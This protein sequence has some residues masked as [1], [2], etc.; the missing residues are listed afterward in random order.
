MQDPPHDG[1]VIYSL[2]EFAMF[3]VARLIVADTPEDVESLQVLHKYK[4]TFTVE[5]T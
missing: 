2:D 1:N 5:M 4:G 3:F